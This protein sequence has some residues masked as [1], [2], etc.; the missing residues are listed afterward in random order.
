MFRPFADPLSFQVPEWR[1]RC[2]QLYT[3]L[4]S[5]LMVR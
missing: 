1:N 4:R 5:Y 3:E 2:Q